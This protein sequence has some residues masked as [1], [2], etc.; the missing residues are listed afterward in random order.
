MP[1]GRACVPAAQ[2]LSAPGTPVTEVSF[3]HAERHRRYSMVSAR[4][5]R[6]RCGHW[7]G[8]RADANGVDGVRDVSEIFLERLI[9]AI[10]HGYRLDDPRD[11]EVLNRWAHVCRDLPENALPLVIPRTL[12]GLLRQPD[13]GPR[14]R[15]V[16]GISE[17]L[18]LQHEAIAPH[19]ISY[20]RYMAARGNDPQNREAQRTIAQLRAELRAL[21]QEFHALFDQAAGVEMERERLSSDN[22]SLQQQ[23]LAERLR[24]EESERRLQDVKDKTFRMFRLYLFMLREERERLSND[25]RRERLLTA[26]I[27]VETHAA[28]LESLGAYAQAEEQAQDILGEPLFTQY[29]RAPEGSGRLAGLTVT[30]PDP[31]DPAPPPREP[32]RPQTLAHDLSEQK[33]VFTLRPRARS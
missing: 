26:E 33:N 24:A 23:L 14:L 2:G 29:F 16:C 7:S 5:L 12:R 3:N 10:R 6:P 27:A 21:R 30:D 1:E 9:E 15:D 18:P 19:V 25:P 31:T 28:T 4:T 22:A 17:T 20:R 32:D 8:H 13:L 11:P